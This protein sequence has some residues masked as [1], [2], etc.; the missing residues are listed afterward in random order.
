I[1]TSSKSLCFPL[2]RRHFGVSA[3]RLLFGFP[4]PRKYSLNGAIPLLVNI[5]VGSFFTTIGADGTMRFCLDLKNSK[6]L[7]RV[8]FEFISYIIMLNLRVGCCDKQ[9]LYL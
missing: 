8:S 1:P 9:F 4:F 3:I 7:E 2:T 5:S 6:N